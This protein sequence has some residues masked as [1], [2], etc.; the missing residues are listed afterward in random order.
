MKFPYRAFPLGASDPVTKQ[1]FAWRPAIKV[2][3]WY[4]HQRSKPLEAVLD[5]GAY[6][7]IFNAEIGEALRVPITKGVPI[8][9]T[10]FVRSTSVPAFYT[11][12]KSRLLHKPTKR[13]SCLLTALHRSESLDKLDFSITSSL[14]LIG[15]SIHPVL[16]FREF[17]TIRYSRGIYFSERS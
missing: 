3:L 14:R 5:T 6:H 1:D 2:L 12:C 10:S 17:H 13:Q 7:C 16:I 9:F 8:A 15:Q 4:N 11:G